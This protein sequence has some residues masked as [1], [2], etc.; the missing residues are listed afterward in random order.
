M[1]VVQFKRLLFLLGV[2]T[3]YLRNPK[4]HTKMLW[5]S[6]RQECSIFLP[7]F[8]AAIYLPDPG[9]NPI[10]IHLYFET[11]LSRWLLSVSMRLQFHNAHI[12]PSF[13]TFQRTLCFAFH[14]LNW[15]ACGLLIQLTSLSQD[16]PVL[17]YFSIYIFEAPSSC[18]A[19]KGNLTLREETSDFGIYWMPL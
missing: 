10:K 4:I 1:S 13:S 16:P 3:N 2:R 15:V 8:K 14:G 6:Q 12:L 5:S 19:T 7:L 18:T 17:G 11:I 9:P